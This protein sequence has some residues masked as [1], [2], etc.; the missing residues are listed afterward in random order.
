[1]KSQLEKEIP[2]GI[3]IS[4]SNMLKYICKC[5]KSKELQ[6]ATLEVKDGKVRTKE[7]ECSC[8]KHMQEVE[9]DFD[10]FPSLIRTEETLNK[11][12]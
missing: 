4:N 12:V 9:K 1:M 7:A 6:K 8:G 10:G 3:T 2:R 5:G 11:K